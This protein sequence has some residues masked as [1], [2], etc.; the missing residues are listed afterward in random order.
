M[1]RMIRYIDTH[2]W[3]QLVIIVITGILIAWMFAEAI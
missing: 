3:I 2:V 1:N